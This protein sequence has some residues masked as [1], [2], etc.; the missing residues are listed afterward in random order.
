MIVESGIMNLMFKRSD[1][2]KVSM[3]YEVVG[4]ND[5]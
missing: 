4:Q 3:I 5:C 1:L 2:T